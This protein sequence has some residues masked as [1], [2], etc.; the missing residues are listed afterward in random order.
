MHPAQK[1]SHFATSATAVR[2]YVRL[3]GPASQREGVDPLKALSNSQIRRLPA[4]VL[5]PSIQPHPVHVAT[6]LHSNLP[7]S[8]THS[9]INKGFYEAAKMKFRSAVTTFK[10]LLNVEGK[11][12]QLSE[13]QEQTLLLFFF[14]LNLILQRKDPAASRDLTNFL[15]SQRNQLQTHLI[16]EHNILDRI[17]RG[18]KLSPT[19]YQKYKDFIR[20][21]AQS[22]IS[23]ACQALREWRT[24]W[25]QGVAS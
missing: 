18:E 19:E 14:N 2:A 8:K 10:A 6:S 1:S 7:F 22:F 3:S 4:E 13:S 23:N 9:F 21:E 20:N 25:V 16:E 5:I 17:E 24:T 12:E 15:G 11:S